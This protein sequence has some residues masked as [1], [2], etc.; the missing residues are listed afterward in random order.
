MLVVAFVRSIPDHPFVGCRG[1]RGDALG[2]V[3]ADALGDALGSAPGS[4]L[5]ANV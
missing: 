2:N 3:L 4:A 1:D 5:A